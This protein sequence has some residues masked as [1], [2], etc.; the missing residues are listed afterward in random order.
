[1]PLSL[2]SDKKF[3]IAGGYYPDYLIWMSG[4]PVMIV[5][6][7]HPDRDVITGFRE[8]SQYA[9]QVTTSEAM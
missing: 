2:R 9:R 4:Y 1:V 3:G 6:A 7:K 5:E 8:A